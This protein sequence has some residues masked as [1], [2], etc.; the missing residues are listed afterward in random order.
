MMGVCANHTKSVL[1]ANE[2]SNED[3][4]IKAVTTMERTA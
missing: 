4:D 3:G 2:K 1:N